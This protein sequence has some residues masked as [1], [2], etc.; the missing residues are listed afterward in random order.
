MTSYDLKRPRFG[1]RTAQSKTTN[2]GI[3]AA[4]GFGGRAGTMAHAG[5]PLRGMSAWTSRVT[6]SGRFVPLNSWSGL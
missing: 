1:R 6:E 5:L 4:A 2:G 3:A